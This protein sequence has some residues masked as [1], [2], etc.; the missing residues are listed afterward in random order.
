MVYI[1]IARG[2]EDQKRPVGVQLQE[3]AV[4]AAFIFYAVTIGEFRIVTW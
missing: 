4:L 1:K 2:G 3:A